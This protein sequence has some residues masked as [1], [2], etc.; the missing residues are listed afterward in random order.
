MPGWNAIDDELLA[1]REAGRTVTFWWRDDD[2]RDVTPE[3]DRLLAIARGTDTPVALSVIP[4]DAR[5]QLVAWLAGQPLGCALVHGWGHDNHAPAD[6]RQN[7]YGPHRPRDV[8]LAELRRAVARVSA[9]ARY[10]PVLVAPWNRIDP[11]LVP[12]LPT[13]GVTGLSVLG[14]RPARELVPGLVN[15]NVHVDIVDWQGTGGFVGTEAA[16]A[17]VLAHLQQRR[18]GTADASE[19]TGLMTHH[20]FHDEGCWHFVEALVRR[21]RAHPAC[22]WLAAGEVFA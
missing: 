21:M 6:E 11:D 2:A 19:P 18:A 15:A 22:R 14:P 3:L 16:L 9:F 8:M 12:A 7:E 17:Q 4:R 1:W 5:D 20:L 13:A 10:V